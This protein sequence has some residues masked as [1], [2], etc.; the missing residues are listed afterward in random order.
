[1]AVVPPNN[2][3][4]R[5]KPLPRHGKTFSRR[6]KDRPDE[7]RLHLWITRN[8]EC[9]AGCGGDGSGIQV[10]G[11]VNGIWLF[12]NGMFVCFECLCIVSPKS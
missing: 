9:C 6:S 2:D 1:M 8:G 7:T 5:A 11:K 3:F 12:P 10:D 4:M